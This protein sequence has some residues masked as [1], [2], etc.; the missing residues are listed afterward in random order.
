[1]D[2]IPSDT[3]V[4]GLFERILAENPELS[5]L[6]Q[7]LAQIISLSSDDNASI[8]QLADV[9]RRDPG[10]TARM[11]RAAN[12]PAF[13]QARDVGSINKATQLIGFRSALSFALASSVYSLTDSLNGELSRTRFWRHALETAVAAKLLAEVM[14]G[15]MPGAGLK[16]DPGEAFI[17]G[18][19]HDIG[20]LILDNSFSVRYQEI[21]NEV[22]AGGKLCDLETE[23]WGAS[24]AAAGEFILKQWNIPARISQAVGNHHITTSALAKAGSLGPLDLCVALANTL[25]RNRMFDRSGDA[26]ERHELRAALI[27]KL[28]LSNES[29][30]GIEE[31]MAEE[32]IAQAS[33]LQIDV[34]DKNSM[35]KD[36]NRALYAQYLLVE[37]LL[38]KNRELQDEIVR[39]KTE[40][41]FLKSLHAIS[42]S[43]NHYLNNANATIQ[44]HVQLLQI[45]A[46]RGE[47]TDPKGVIDRSSEIIQSSVDVMKA[48]LRAI[49]ELTDMRTVHYHEGLE[50]I[51]LEDKIAKEKINIEKLSRKLIPATIES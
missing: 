46:S 37:D 49:D 26:V 33:Y 41:S 30:F 36:A 28:S 24:H 14:S 18:L 4:E 6:P 32:L 39:E 13:G 21:F 20:M 7:T 34:G 2:P 23:E 29:L 51:D 11:L 47:I 50:I 40:K 25:T 17:A 35:L 48:T 3:H 16:V 45:R 31:K 43:Y 19:L 10:L 5:S 1:M 44:G 27:Q 15:A 22:E 12:S 9:I 38:N 42:G 8:N